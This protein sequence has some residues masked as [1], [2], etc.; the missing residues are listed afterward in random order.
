MNPGSIRTFY[1]ARRVLV[2]LG[3]A[4]PVLVL[5]GVWWL[6]TQ[7]LMVPAVPDG[8]TP[9]DRVASFMMHEKGLPRLHGRQATV[10]LEQQV[11]R[12][13]DDDAFRT[14]FLAEIRT[15]SPEDQKA[16]RSAL[17]DIFK[18]MLLED[19]KH[20]QELE[21]TARRDYLDERIVAYNRLAVYG[22]KTKI[23]ANALGAAAPSGSEL[24]QMVMA[25]T[26]EEERQLGMAY[27][28]AVKARVDEI[29][30]DPE[31]KADFEARIA[32]PAR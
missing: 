1:Q 29:L 24:L 3:C 17:F 20:Y 30:A 8:T 27:G 10:F 25:K 15:A 31:L 16:F 12:L 5:A 28:T 11:R 22:G 14:R 7:V 26:T 4:A 19:V 23:S 9:P 2:I 21:G 13:V 6:V 18:P 32:A